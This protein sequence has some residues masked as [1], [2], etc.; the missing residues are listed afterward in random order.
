MHPA[1]LRLMTIVA[2]AARKR[3][4]EVSACGALA[5][6]I[7]GIAALI[8]MGIN[9]LSLNV[10]AVSTVKDIARRLSEAECA[11]LVREAVRM[12]DAV[13]VRQAFKKLIEERVAKPDEENFQ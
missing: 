1:V 5:A 2:E 13:S 11:R 12:S 8:G 7:E 10:S 9:K 6:D 4:I 3:K